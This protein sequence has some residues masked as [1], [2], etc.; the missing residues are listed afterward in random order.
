MQLLATS[1]AVAMNQ[2][3]VDSRQAGIATL[4]SSD[5]MELFQP[6]PKKKV[7]QLISLVTLGLSMTNSA[8][9]QFGPGASVKA[10]LSQLDGQDSGPA[11]SSA[12]SICSTNGDSVPRMINSI[13]T[14]IMLERLRAQLE[15]GDPAAKF[16]VEMLRRG[17]LDTYVESA[18]L[19]WEDE[20]ESLHD[21][22]DSLDD[23]GV[24]YG[25]AYLTAPESSLDSGRHVPLPAM[26]HSEIAS[27][28]S[29][30]RNAAVPWLQSLQSRSSSNPTVPNEHEENASASSSSG[31]SS[32]GGASADQSSSESST[33][34]P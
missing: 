32:S 1:V 24:P 2:A 14:P 3:L 30:V 6:F 4:V 16:A 34:N 31:N 20:F 7:R 9:D 25:S 22:S 10:W 19:P 28:A 29:V 21:P 23:D 12:I 13:E 26:S 8:R 11:E 18:Y 17:A 15:A 5:Q 33:K 27:E